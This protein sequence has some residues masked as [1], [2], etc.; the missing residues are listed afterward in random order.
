M[1]IGGINEPVSRA[2]PCLAERGVGGVRFGRGREIDHELRD[3]QFA[4]GRAEPVVGVP[5]GERLNYRLR[6][7]EAD[8]LD[9]GAGQ[10]AQM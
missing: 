4:F 9:R 1:C 7:G 2:M 5:G 6:L 10:P 8:I 3:R